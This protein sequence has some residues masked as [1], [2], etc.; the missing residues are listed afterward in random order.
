M[1]WYPLLMRHMKEVSGQAYFDVNEKA[2]KRCIKAYDRFLCV[3]AL[4]VVFCLL[5][6]MMGSGAA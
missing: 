6:V 4:V 1:S 5:V 3:C 2:I